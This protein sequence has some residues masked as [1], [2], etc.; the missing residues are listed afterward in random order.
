MPLLWSIDI[1]KDL[2]PSR[3]GDA[4]SAEP[5]HKIAHAKPSLG[6]RQLHFSQTRAMVNRAQWLETAVLIQGCDAAAMIIRDLRHQLAQESGIE[7]GHV[8]CN[9]QAPLRGH[10]GER[11][12]QAADGSVPLVNIFHHE[13]SQIAVNLW[14]AKNS[15]VADGVENLSKNGLDERFPA[16]IE[17]R[18]VGSHAAA[19]APGEDEAADPGVDNLSRVHEKMVARP[20]PARPGLPVY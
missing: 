18:F 4:V 14:I 12:V 9:Q 1:P 7:T 10:R 8:A 13:H 2:T 3:V 19:A 6:N 17:K 5:L 11:R 20:S 15:S 16:M